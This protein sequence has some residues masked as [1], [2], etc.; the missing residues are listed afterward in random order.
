MRS[1]WSRIYRTV[2]PL[3]VVL[4]V[5]LV[6]LK[7]FG[8]SVIFVKGDSME[9]NYKGGEI[10]LIS[11]EDEYERGD[12]VCVQLEDTTILKRIIAI[13]GDTIE[14]YHHC[15]WVNG[16]TVSPYIEGE[17]WNNSGDFDIC[18][19]IGPGEVFLLGDNRN[20]SFDSRYPEIGTIKAEQIT[21]RVIVK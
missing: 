9:P 20:E 16:E 11:K 1:I 18:Q 5:V 15:I 8:I 21:G 6:V 7:A 19:T 4:C 3:L 17:N 10:H 12:V 13:G 14:I 2:M